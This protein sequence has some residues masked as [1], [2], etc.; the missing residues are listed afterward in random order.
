MQSFSH[1][2]MVRILIV[3]EIRLMADIMRSV[4]EN[5]DD[6]TVVDVTTSKSG[7]LSRL[8]EVDMVLV[9][10]TL[11]DDE[12]VEVTQAASD[13]DLIVLV[14]G[15]RDVPIRIIKYIEAGAAGYV[16]RSDSVEKLLENVRISKKGKA[17]VSPRIAAALI[18][19][20]SELADIRDDQLNLDPALPLEL[21]PREREVLE[22]IGEHKTNQQIA[23][24][25]FIEVGTV[26]NHVH[27]ILNKL[28]VR[29]RQEAAL[30]LDTFK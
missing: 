27:N 20:V 26:K 17:L 30:Y 24:D 18:D 6:I 10:S 8:D 9:S 11:P 23:D 15:V 5:E 7:A 14:I 2:L 4:L 1:I 22:H 16:L 29:S 13:K 25:L 21:T 28:N 19:R 12:A 3:E